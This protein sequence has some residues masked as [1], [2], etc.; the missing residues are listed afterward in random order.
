MLALVDPML[1]LCYCAQAT[2]AVSMSDYV[3]PKNCTILVGSEDNGTPRKLIKKLR[4][5][6]D[7]LVYE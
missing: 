5:G 1:C 6:Y 7:G 2:G 3:F 4:P